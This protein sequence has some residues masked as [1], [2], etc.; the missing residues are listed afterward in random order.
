M[1]RKI[2][3]AEFIEYLFFSAR[4]DILKTWEYRCPKAAG[5]FPISES[6]RLSVGCSLGES[7][8]RVLLKTFIY[9]VYACSYLG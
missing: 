5:S 8:M 2:T 9:T 3:T 6:P 1:E 4:C 7:R